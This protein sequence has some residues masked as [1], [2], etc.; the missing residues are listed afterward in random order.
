MNTHIASEIFEF[1]TE[2]AGPY[3]WW[4][5]GSF[6]LSIALFL[7]PSSIVVPI[8]RNYSSPEVAPVLG[9]LRAYLDATTLAQNLYRAVIIIAVVLQLFFFVKTVMRGARYIFWVL[10]L[11]AIYFGSLF[12]ILS[13]SN[14]FQIGNFIEMVTEDIRQIEEGELETAVIH[15]SPRYRPVSIIGPLDPLVDYQS[16][17]ERWSGIRPS[18]GMGWEGFTFPLAMGFE[19][20]TNREF[21]DRRSV[22]E[23]MQ[24]AQLYRVTFTS[25]LRFVYAVEMVDAQYFLDRL[26]PPEPRDMGYADPAFF[27]TWYFEDDP[28]WTMIFHENGGAFRGVEGD[29]QFF[30][31][32]IVVDGILSTSTEIEFGRISTESWDYEIIDDR[33][34]LRSRRAVARERNYVRQIAE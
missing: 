21:S 24:H 12:W 28:S 9:I 25:N 6:L 20:N 26:P 32:G 5:L 3:A 7:A 2:K 27:G 22:A 4:M 13:F 8:L 16:P 31:W 15:I 18:E 14:V 17:V 29:M 1:I 34:F 23:N 10:I 11:V 33:L 19:R 30:S